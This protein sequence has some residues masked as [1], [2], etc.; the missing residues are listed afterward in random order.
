MP[1]AETLIP[2]HCRITS[3]IPC[4]TFDGMSLVHICNSV[5]RRH[6]TSN[7][8]AF[9]Q[10]DAAAAFGGVENYFYGT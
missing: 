3:F 4:W 5:V 9:G 2:V 7:S 6:I 10:N 8:A 1:S